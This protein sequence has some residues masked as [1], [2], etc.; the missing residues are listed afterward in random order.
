MADMAEAFTS[1]FA[2]WRSNSHDDQDT[3]HHL[4]ELLNSALSVAEQVFKQRGVYE[5]SWE[6]SERRYSMTSRR[7][8]VTPELTKVTDEQG[9]LI[10]KPQ[11]LVTAIEES[12]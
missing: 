7:I 1:A 11:V 12:I 3:R 5:T 9:R 4:M 8:I 2:P 10:E 6:H